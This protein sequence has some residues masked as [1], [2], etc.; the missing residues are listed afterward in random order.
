MQLKGLTQKE[1][2]MNRII[3]TSF[4]VLALTVGLVGCNTMNTAANTG[5]TVVKTGGKVVKAGVGVVST[6]GTAVVTTVGA[7]I[8][9]LVGRRA[10]SHD[11]KV[12]Q[13]KGVIY[14]NGHQYRVENGRYVLVR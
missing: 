8:D 14:R 2:I 13:K 4:S 3:L 9:T 11:V 5:V 1:F 10:S 12:Y 7:G 6:A